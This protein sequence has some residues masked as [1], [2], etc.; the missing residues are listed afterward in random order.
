MG[1]RTAIF[2]DRH[3]RKTPGSNAFR[4]IFICRMMATV[5]S[6]ACKTPQSL[7]PNYLQVKGQKQTQVGH[8]RMFDHVSA[9][10]AF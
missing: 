3:E 6:S 8:V 4:S 2:R 9:S 1:G 7:A 5:C 10:T